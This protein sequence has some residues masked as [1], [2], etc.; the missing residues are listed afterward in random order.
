[1]RALGSTATLPMWRLRPTR[2]LPLVQAAHL[3]VH[4]R[5]S[6]YC[7][8]PPPTS[9]LLVLYPN[10]CA[11]VQLMQKQTA[12]RVAPR[13]D[14]ARSVLH[15]TSSGSH[16]RSRSNSYVQGRG[17]LIP[18]ERYTTSSISPYNTADHPPPIIF[19]LENP[20]QTGVPIVDLLNKTDSFS[21]IRDPTQAFSHMGK[22]TFTLRVQVSSLDLSGKFLCG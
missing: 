1:M 20:H 21:R 10:S 17:P 5:E 18:Q 9:V 8:R 2:F 3:R 22:K 15:S 11:T 12:R 14:R 13:H 4:P 7:R 19:D 6:V 16:G